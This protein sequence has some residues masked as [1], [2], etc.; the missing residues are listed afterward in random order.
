MSEKYVCL[1]AEPCTDHQSLETM[2][3][4]PSPYFRHFLVTGVYWRQGQREDGIPHIVIVSMLFS[5]SPQRGWRLANRKMMAFA[6]VT[7]NQIIKLFC[8][9][10]LQR[11]ENITNLSHGGTTGS[12]PQR[13]LKKWFL[14]N[15]FSLEIDKLLIK[16]RMTV[17]YLQD[18][19]TISRN[20]NSF[21]Q[22]S[23]KQ[24]QKQTPKH[25]DF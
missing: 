21:L 2:M 12:S 20:K 13:F 5:K 25:T 14:S 4:T 24:K 16:N 22:E 23:K 1:M 15:S 8:L 11:S 19:M 10:T 18:T 7:S 17:K 3:S 6:K 9:Q